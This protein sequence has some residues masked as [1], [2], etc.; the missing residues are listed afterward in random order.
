MTV[1]T[2]SI[3]MDERVYRQA[4]GAADRA[5]TSVSGWMS[6]AAREKL[7]RDAAAAVAEADRRTGGIWADWAEASEREFDLPDTGQGAA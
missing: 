6:R 3:S 7:Q 1:R 2:F 4:K 5:G